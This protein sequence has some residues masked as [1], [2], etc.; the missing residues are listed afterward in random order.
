MTDSTSTIKAILLTGVG[1]YGEALGQAQ[2]HPFTG[3][4]DSN[5]VVLIKGSQ[6]ITAGCMPLS[7][8]AEQGFDPDFE[9]AMIPDQFEVLAEEV[10]YSNIKLLNDSLYQGAGV[11]GTEVQGFH[12]NA[13]MGGPAGYC[14]QG[15]QLTSICDGFTDDEFLYLWAEENVEVLPVTLQ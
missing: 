6:F 11:A 10:V 7:A 1:L 13:V 15:N 3:R 9:Y 8:D 5:G 14:V 12:I 2:F 4:V